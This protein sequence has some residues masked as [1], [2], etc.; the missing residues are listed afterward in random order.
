MLSGMTAIDSTTERIMSARFRGSLP[1]SSN[2]NCALNCKK[3]RASS[4]MNAEN[5]SLPKDFANESGS[6]PS[7]NRTTLT[8]M[9]SCKSM[10]MPR[11]EARMPAES[12]SKMTVTFLVN[13]LSK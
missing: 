5:L 2:S 1:A 7:G 10:S 4:R 13:R 9:P 3:S 11:N 8:A 12:P 6:S